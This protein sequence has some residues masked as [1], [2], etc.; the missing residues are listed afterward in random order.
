MFKLAKEI[1][2]KSNMLWK[3]GKACDVLVSFIFFFKYTFQ[4]Y[5]WNIL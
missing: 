5:L 4:I 1:G 2:V 3:S